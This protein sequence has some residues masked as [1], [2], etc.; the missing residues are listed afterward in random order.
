MKLSRREAIKYLSAIPGMRLLPVPMFGKGTG[1]FPVPAAE[2]FPANPLLTGTAKEPGQTYKRLGYKQFFLDFQFSDVDPDTMKHADAEKYAEAAAQM[3]A[4][5]MVVY[6]IT[7]KGLALYKSRFAPKLT[8]LSDDF[9]GDYLA[10][11]RKRNIKTVIYHCLCWQR[12]QDGDHPD[13]AVMDSHSQPVFNPGSPLGFMGRTNYLCLNSPFRELALNQVKEIADRYTF[14]GW[15]ID[16]FLWAKKL[17]CYNPHCLE[18]W[19]AQYGTDL[20]RPLPDE[21]YPQY[22]NFTLDTYRSTYQAIKDQLKASGHD[23]P[24]THNESFDFSLDDYV[25]M[26]TGS[27]G[28]DYCEP[29]VNTKLYRAHAHGRELQ[30]S[31]HLNNMYLDYVNTPLPTVRWMAATIVSHNAALTPGQQTNLDGTIDPA[32]IRLG[33]EAFRVAD[34][35]IPKVRGTVPYGEIA[36][37]ASERDRALTDNDSYRDFYGANKLLMDLHWPFDVVTTEHLGADDLAAFRLL[38]IPNVKHLSP[39]QRQMLLNYLHKGGT[40]FFCGHCAGCDEDGKPY[41]SP[42]FGLVEIEKETH[43]P[44]GFIKPTFPND[45]ERLKAADIMTVKSDP[46]LKVWGWLFR[47][48]MTSREGTHLDDVRYPMEATN[49]PVIVSGME[50]GGNFIYAAYRFFQ[51]YVNQ[52]LP[53]IGQTFE[54]L[55]APHYQ[56]SVWVEAPSAIEAIY[57]LAGQELRVALVNGIT[58]RPA[59]DGNWVGSEKHGYLNIVEVVPVANCRILLRGIKA[60]KALNLNGEPLRMTSEGDLMAISV[61]RLEQYDLISLELG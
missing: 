44:R 15:F 13:W 46:R 36:I 37:V 5:T 58:G 6:A 57:N 3:G 25:F 8:N 49:L 60:G 2:S 26:E 56:P 55:V 54:A 11:C 1:E 32:T 23:V 24:V 10:A 20:P 18:K 47:S 59:G 21:L 45:D 51:E 42:N 7:A 27:R 48:S 4:E 9:L 35:L 52:G 14:D 17:V 43:F 53:V 30:I 31:P 16:L 39:S 33:Q 61:P 22:L 12:I 19:K 29:S 50:G 38:I 28:Y 41:T 40:I 34:R